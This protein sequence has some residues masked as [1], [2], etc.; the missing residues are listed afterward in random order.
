MILRN[1][2]R[3]LSQGFQLL[4]KPMDQISLSLRSLSEIRSR[5]IIQRLRALFLFRPP[6]PLDFRLSGFRKLS[7]NFRNFFRQL[8]AQSDMRR[9]VSENPPVSFGL[10]SRTLIRS[11]DRSRSAPGR[12]CIRR[13]SPRSRVRPRASAIRRWRSAP[14]RPASASR[15]R[16]LGRLCGSR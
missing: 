11:S 8:S 1:F 4:L 15:L 13:P 9:Q 12:T 16:A 14:P 5:P 6:M 7:V 2:F 3:P 10:F